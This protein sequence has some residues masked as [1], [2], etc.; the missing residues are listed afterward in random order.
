M[1]TA[2]SKRATIM[3]R[4]SYYRHAVEHNKAD[5]QQILDLAEVKPEQIQEG[6]AGVA[7]EVPLRVLTYL[8]ESLM[9]LGLSIAQIQRPEGVKPAN[10]GVLTAGEL[11]KVL[12]RVPDDTPILIAGG[13]DHSYRKPSGAEVNLA[14]Y[15]QGYFG[16]WYGRK[17]ASP[18]E[19]PISA[20]IISL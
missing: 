13:P 1:T 10:Y 18:G 14:G 16:E 8:Y 4:T 9:S 12:D 7:I 11:R 20:I 19:R 15:A 6:P 2:P 5:L 17:H 3:V